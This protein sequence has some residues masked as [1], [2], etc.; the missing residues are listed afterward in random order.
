MRIKKIGVHAVEQYDS[1]NG[2][3]LVSG[4]HGVTLHHAEGGYEGTIS[5]QMNPDQRYADGTKVN[6]CSTWIIGKNSGQVAQMKDTAYIA[7]CE[8][9]GSKLWR[10]IELA[11]YAS[12]TPTPWQVECAAYILVEMH[13]VYGVP[14]TVADHPGERGLGHH[15]M[16][17][18]W[19]GEEWGHEA[20]PGARTINVKAAIVA[21]AN[22]IAYPPAPPEP[23]NPRAPRRAV[24]LSVARIQTGA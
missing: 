14:L 18:E 4:T 7:W 9:A 15:S 24:P 19:L 10:S 8:R 21:L 12:E 23:A 3:G 11:G 6:T 2:G 20:C 17:R 5:W 13:Q 16:D 22:R 1:P